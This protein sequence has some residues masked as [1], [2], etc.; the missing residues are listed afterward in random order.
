MK[1]RHLDHH[2]APLTAEELCALRTK[3]R[4]IFITSRPDDVTYE[5]QHITAGGRLGAKAGLHLAH[6]IMFTTPNTQ[7]AQRV[8]DLLAELDEPGTKGIDY[9]GF[10]RATQGCSLQDL[11]LLRGIDTRAGGK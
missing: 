3:L 6:P 5:Y 11:G 2:G 8:L 9:V 7:K 1:E 4:D 10:S